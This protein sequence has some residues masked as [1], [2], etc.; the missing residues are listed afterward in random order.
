MISELT[1]QDE[2]KKVQIIRFVN[3]M[4]AAFQ[5]MDDVLAVESDDYR[6]ARGAYCEDIQEGKRT[7]MVI[8]SY[9]YGWKGDR[10]LEI[11]NMRTNDEE[12]HKEAIKILKEDEAV[13]FARNTAKQTMLKAWRAIDPILPESEAKDDLGRLTNFLIQRQI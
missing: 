9:F 12:M 4:G 3:M 10:L 2:E 6:K 8:H 11:L 13:E 7:L 5:I 1:G